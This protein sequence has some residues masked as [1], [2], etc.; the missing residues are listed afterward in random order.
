MDYQDFVL[1]CKNRAGKLWRV[2]LRTPV[3]ETTEKDQK[4]YAR[5]MRRVWPEYEF[6]LVKRR[7]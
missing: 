1:L 2:W 4:K 3:E 5:E 6:K 7:S